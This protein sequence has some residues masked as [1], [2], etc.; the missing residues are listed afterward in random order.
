MRRGHSAARHQHSAAH[1][2]HVWSVCETA[3]P[4]SC[5]AARPPVR[6]PRP[7]GS[8]SGHPAVQLGP[9][10]LKPELVYTR[11]SGYGER[12]RSLPMPA[13]EAQRWP[14]TPLLL[15][16]CPRQPACVAA[17]PAPHAPL[18]CPAFGTCCRPDGATCAAAR[19]RQRVRGLWRVPV[20]VRRL[21]LRAAR[22]AGAAPVPPAG[23]SAGWRLPGLWR[24]L[25]PARAQPA[26][27]CLPAACSYINGFPD[28]PPV[29]P[30]ISLGDSLAGLHAAFGTVMAL[31]HR[32]RLGAGAAG[33]V[34]RSWAEGSPGRQMDRG[35]VQGSR[36]PAVLGL[37]ER[38]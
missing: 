36:E 12:P 2:T 32:S 34:R 11:I 27:L 13:A 23:S 1:L 6:L 30:N 5:L 8:L 35:P 15:N 29:R 37:L 3:K 9:K 7:K 14:G 20:R 17:P 21:S 16:T 38:G 31:L 10:D 24:A 28:R 26:P 22:K 18:L 4:P 19:L 25:S 33:Q